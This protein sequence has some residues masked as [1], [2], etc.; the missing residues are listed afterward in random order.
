MTISLEGKRRCGVCREHGEVRVVL[1]GAGTQVARRA[2]AGVMP[3]GAPRAE[4]HPRCGT[5]SNR[6]AA[7]VTRSVTPAVRSPESGPMDD[8]YET[9][10]RALY[11]SEEQGR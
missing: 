7:P 5:A 8:V 11:L 10:V 2:A 1:D 9:I 6:T 4:R 3:G